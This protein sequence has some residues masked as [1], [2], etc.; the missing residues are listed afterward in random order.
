MSDI[1]NE[2]FP[3]MF[4]FIDNSTPNF[5][6]IASMKNLSPVYNPNWEADGDLLSCL[7]YMKEYIT[8]QEISSINNLQIFQEKNITPALF[9]T[10][11]PTDKEETYTILFYSHIDKIPFGDGWSRCDPNDP[12]VIDGFLYGRGVATSLYAIF[13]IIGMIKIIDELSLPRP[14]IAVLIESSFESGSPD[15]TNNLMKALNIV[16][17][18]NQVICLSTWGPVSDYFHYMKSCRGT[19]SFDVKIT[20]AQKDVHSGSFGGIIPDPMMIFNNILSNKIEKIVKSDDGKATNIEIPLLEKEITEEQKKECENVT[21]ICDFKMWTIFMYDGFSQFIGSKNEDER[22]DFCTAYING[23]LRPSYSILGFEDMP[24]I[25]NASG[26]LK[27]CVNARL[28]FRT[29]PTLDVNEACENLKNAILENPLF[30]AKIEIL[31]EDYCQGFDLEE[32]NN[33][34]TENMIKCFNKYSDIRIGNESLGLR[35]ARTLPCL[36]YLNAKLKNVPFF[37]TGVGNTFSDNLRDANECIKL[38]LVKSYSSV[39]TCY[40][41]DYS[42]YKEQNKK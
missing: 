5:L 42:S 1:M 38:L 27:S 15:L 19:I 6:K 28:C 24:T 10:V 32:N 8:S 33:N 30:G 26:S 34:M 16:G 9:F 39:L 20:T 31:N 37:V 7:A 12:K 3:R 41:S 23:V 14:K 13:T 36:N 11:S 18:V 29:P 22:E 17:S 21:K 25:E 2:V 4:E 35:M 40:V